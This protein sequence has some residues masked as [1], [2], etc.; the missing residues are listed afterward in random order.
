MHGIVRRDGTLQK[1]K[2]FIP[3]SNIENLT[4][5]YA[6]LAYDLAAHQEI[7]LNKGSHSSIYFHSY[8][9]YCSLPG[10]L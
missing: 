3:D 8:R 1:M 5:P 9:I 10:C 6:A 4:I 2:E 7:T